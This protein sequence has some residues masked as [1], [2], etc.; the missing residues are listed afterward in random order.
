MVKQMLSS[1]ITVVLWHDVVAILLV[2][3]KQAGNMAPGASSLRNVASIRERNC[4]IMP[5]STP[6]REISFK[7]CGDT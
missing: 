6:T 1:K 7:S 5:R 2:I 4:A 3:M